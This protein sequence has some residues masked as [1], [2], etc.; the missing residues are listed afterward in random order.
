MKA[1]YSP[2]W[3]LFLAL[4]VGVG[5]V[6]ALAY[7]PEQTS[8]AEHPDYG[9]RYVEGVAGSPSKVNPLFANFNDVDADLSGL[10]FSG[11]V[12][13]G[14]SGNVQPDLASLPTIAP[15]G[16][17]YLF[18]L[19]EGL[20][21]H[22]GEPITSAD[23]VFTVNTIQ[24]LDFNG[25]PELAELFRSVEV[26]AYGDQA[27]VM[28]LPEPYAPFLA[29]AATV[30]ILPVHLLG[31]LT[32]SQM[33]DAPFNQTPIG[34]GP[35][36]LVELTAEHALLHRFPDY[37]GGSPYLSELELRFYPD[38]AALLAALTDD[39]VSGGL[40]RPGLDRRAID[41]ID[42]DGNLMRRSLHTTASSLVYLNQQVPMFTESFLRR[43][44]QHGLDR[45]KV[46]DAA[47]EGQG[48]LTDSPIVLDMWSHDGSPEAY[49]Y[50]PELAKTLLDRAGW[51]MQG[52]IRANAFG[53]PL[54]FHLEASDDPVQMAIAEDIARQ[55]N[56]LGAQVDV[57]VSGASQ[58]VEGVLLPR[59]FD[60][61][62][63]TIDTGPDPDP[64]PFWHS[65]QRFGDGRNLG[66][67]A[68]STVD[69]LLENARQTTSAA[70]RA[71]A[72]R[73]FQ[74]IFSQVAPAVLLATPSYQYVVD[75]D[76]RGVSPG[77]LPTLASRFRDVQDW[78][79]ETTSEE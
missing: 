11:L 20:T 57:V 55:W 38:D 63:V 67:F 41:A 36:R 28:I 72:Y 76:V 74:V 70:E 48:L 33:G 50:D 49:G 26:A 22:D 10:V 45:Q 4:L 21:W 35:F 29:R 68:D 77:L 17:T 62:L 40:F 66:G 69:E 30:G 19:K 59:Q 9:G 43:A 61:A 25:D 64:Y 65:A 24:S 42:D 71:A 7:W 44:L 73:Q 75:A 79:V 51:T 47:L 6:V 39:E 78:Y 52:D 18:Q 15:D 37:R 58:F 56:E 8:G 31:G 5:I 3:P 1:L 60:A 32:A 34:S 2:R 54:Q 27:I 12:R 23:V 46:L 13:L 14:T 16:K 53:Q